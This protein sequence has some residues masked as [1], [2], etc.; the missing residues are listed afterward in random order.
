MNAVQ[1][2]HMWCVAQLVSNSDHS[3]PYLPT[4]DDFLNHTRALQSLAANI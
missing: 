3:G 2:L 1:H 4:G